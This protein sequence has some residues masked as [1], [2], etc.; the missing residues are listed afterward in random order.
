M[1]AESRNLSQHK[2]KGSNHV[3]R[4]SSSSRTSKKT[5]GQDVGRAKLSL[6]FRILFLSIRLCFQLSLVRET[7]GNCGD[8]RGQQQQQKA[9]HLLMKVARVCGRKYGLIEKR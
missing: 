5:L 9:Q 7:F 8:V 6:T 3:G 4:D 2:L 1:D